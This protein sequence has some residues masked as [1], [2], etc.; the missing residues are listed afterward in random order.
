MATLSILNLDHGVPT[1]EININNVFG[2]DPEKNWEL[3]KL[4]PQKT[5][6]FIYSVVFFKNWFDHF[7]YKL[8]CIIQN[9]EF[10]L[11]KMGL[12]L[13]HREALSIRV[14][15]YLE[16]D[17]ENFHMLPSNSKCV[18][19]NVIGRV[20]TVYHRFFSFYWA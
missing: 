7:V 19:D 13:M 4:K 15:N 18:G 16:N 14:L 2:K 9:L 10:F 20:R 6:L 8:S 12:P 3:N 5:K 11:S 17:F 1:F